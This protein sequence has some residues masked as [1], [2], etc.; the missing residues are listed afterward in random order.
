MYEKSLFVTYLGDTPYIRVLDYFISNHVFDCSVQD[1]AEGT[2][3]ARNTVKKVVG[4]MTKAGL[5][6]GTRSV[7]RAVMYQL[8][9]ENRE[10]RLLMEFDWK[11]SKLK[12]DEVEEN[13]RQKV[14]AR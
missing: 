9:S 4:E 1:V 6:R 3:L 10:V 8:N 11:I 13:A 2:E 12:A 7:G 5:V 14:R